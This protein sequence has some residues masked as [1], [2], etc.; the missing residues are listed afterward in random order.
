MSVIFSEMVETDLLSELEEAAESRNYRAFEYLARSSDYSAYDSFTLRQ[1]L[2]LA[3]MLDMVT[4]ARELAQKGLCLFPQ[5]KA[6]QQ[7]AVVLAPPQILGTH[8]AKPTSLPA[9]Q[10]WLKN[11][12]TQYKGKW[13]AVS[14]GKLLGTATSLKELQ[15]QTTNLGQTPGTIIVKVLL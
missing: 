1:A 4:L 2:D 13:V 15:K 3:L 5:E 8:P 11:N 7:A 14:D 6:F 10:E 12:A 9:S